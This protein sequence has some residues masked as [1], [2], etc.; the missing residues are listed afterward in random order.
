MPTFVILLVLSIGSLLG[1]NSQKILLMYNSATMN[2]ADVIGTYVYRV[3]LQEARYS[4]TTAVGL[5]TNILNFI[6]VFGANRIS[7]TITGFSL[8]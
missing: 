6:L 3:G 1:T 2:Q 5:F 8:W 4:Y 7:R